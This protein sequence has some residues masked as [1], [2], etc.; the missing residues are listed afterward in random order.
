MNYYVI[1]AL[2]PLT[3]EREVVSL[4]MTAADARKAIKNEM[5]RPEPRILTKFKLKEYDPKQKLIDIPE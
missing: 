5:K 3:N 1:T 2:N 4:P